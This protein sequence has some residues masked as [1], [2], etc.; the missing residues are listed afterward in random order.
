MHDSSLSQSWSFLGCFMGT[1]SPSRR[2]SHSTRLSLNCLP[3]SQHRRCPV[4]PITA[5]PSGQFDHIPDQ[6]ILIISG[7]REH[8]GMSNDAFPGHDRRSVPLQRACLTPDHCSC[9]A[10]QGLK[11]SPADLGQFELVQAEIRDSSA[12]TLVLL[13]QPLQLFKLS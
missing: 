11:V 2:H 3:A 12:K 4:I 7:L 1:F 8:N 13:L 10:V 5:V 9:G 6:E